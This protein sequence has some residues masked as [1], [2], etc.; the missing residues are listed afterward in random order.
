M[1]WMGCL[2]LPGHLHADSV[3]DGS[4]LGGHS[5]GAGAP[6]AHGFGVLPM[7]VGFEGEGLVAYDQLLRRGQCCRLRK[8]KAAL[9]VESSVFG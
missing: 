5:G 9:I 7:L 8:F 6:E 1:W 2:R 3:R 4:D